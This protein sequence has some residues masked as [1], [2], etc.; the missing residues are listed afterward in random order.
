[1]TLELRLNGS[2]VDH[3]PDG[4]DFAI[5]ETVK[6][7]FG[8]G[9]A[10]AIH[11]QAEELAHRGAAEEQPCSD[12]GGIDG[13]EVDV[14]HQVGNGRDVAFEHSPVARQ[15]DHLVIVP[16]P[17]DDEVTK[18]GPFASV[19]AVD[20]GPVQP[21]EVFH[22]HA[23]RPR[24]S[25]NPHPPHAE[26]VGICEASFG[27]HQVALIVGPDDNRMAIQPLLSAVRAPAAIFC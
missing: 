1:M 23:H 25:A 20:V 17:F 4:F 27:K 19:E 21:R 9:H 12:D 13:E 14:E 8:E 16:G 15:T 3:G 6:D 5:G 11:G 18:T 2:L 22:H 7:V 24:L 26:L 10:P